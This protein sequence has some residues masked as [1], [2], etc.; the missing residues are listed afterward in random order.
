MN[1]NELR[2]TDITYEEY[3]KIK[4]E[5][6]KHL[7]SMPFG[8][9]SCILKYFGDSF[10]H[11]AKLLNLQINPHKRTAKFELSSENVLE[12]I[13]FYREQHDLTRIHSKE[14]WRNPIIF[15]VVFSNVQHFTSDISISDGLIV[16]DTEIA[17]YDSQIGYEILFYFENKEKLKLFCKGANLTID[18]GMVGYYTNGLK[19]IPYCSNCKSKFITT[20]KLTELLKDIEN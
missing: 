3:T 13:N 9:R 17:S 6:Y 12:D 11:D 8:P 2:Y 15:Q 20:K 16:I 10:F 18:S 5:Y 14:F 19:E 1:I 7:L 4:M